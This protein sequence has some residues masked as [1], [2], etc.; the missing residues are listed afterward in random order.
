[1]SGGEGKEDGTVAMG[2][3]V[4]STAA[5]KRSSLH[6]SNSFGDN[7]RKRVV[8][9]SNDAIRTETS[10]RETISLGLQNFS[11]GQPSMMMWYLSVMERSK[12]V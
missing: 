12:F 2:P 9:D 5:L 6:F 1:M 11:S 4:E 8:P 10:F 3:V 7:L